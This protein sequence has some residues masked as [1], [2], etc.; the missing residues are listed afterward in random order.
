[1]VFGQDGE[2]FID[3]H[4][5]TDPY[6]RELERKLRESS[7]DAEKLLGAIG[8][9]W[10]E[11]LADGVSDELGRHGK[12]Y[13]KAVEDATQRTT[14]RIRSGFSVDRRG[15]LHDAAGRFARMFGEEVDEEFERMAAPGG[16]L[17]R[18]GQGFADAIG[19]G[20]NISGRSPLIALLIPI[21]GAIAAAIG[22]AIQAVNAL[23]GLIATLPALL[24]AVGLQVGVL[25]I[26]F[27]GL[28]ERIQ[29]AFAATNAKELEKVLF[30][31]EEPAKRFVRSLLPLRDFWRDLQM[32]VR[33]NFFG[34]LQDPITKILGAL[35][36]PALVGFSNLA[37][38]M[39][40]FF[41]G[42]GTFF[43]SP[44]F[45]DFINDVFPATIRW[46]QQF[47]G[48]FLK[49]LE[50]LIRVADAALPFLESFG[51]LISNNLSLIADVLNENVA[52]GD[53]R[54]WLDSMEDTLVSVF[55]LLGSVIQFTATFLQQLDQ[56]GGK[57]LIDELTRFFGVMTTFLAS[58]LGQKALEGLISAL[59]TS[60]QVTGGLI[61]VLLTL[62]AVAEFVREAIAE[63]FKFL[64]LMFGKAADFI[65]GVAEGIY[66]FF[67]NLG[68]PI[69]TVLTGI[70]DTIVRQFERVENLLFDAGKALV[71][72]FINGI[73]A[74]ARPL[75]E[76]GGFIVNTIKRFLPGSPADE[77][78]FSGSG[79]TLYRGQRM[80][81]DLIKGI[82]MESPELRDASMDAVSNITFGKGAIQVGFEGVV[83]TQ[84]Q[85][86]RTGS[87]VG[88]GITAILAPQRTR[89]A[90][91][92]L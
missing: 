12:D 33:N 73:K 41:N 18:I 55:Q 60:V 43:A 38:A 48:S 62:F 86:E 72:G 65:A 6:E 13:G 30:G 51:R 40:Q 75:E 82:R 49:L 89:L 24:A 15:R 22:A 53:L 50:S 17:N 31:L 61:V 21:F 68:N 3:V 39:G 76:A 87:A 57:K 81:Q 78:P 46:V 16:P 28:G 80:V 63:F 10:G 64:F 37:V 58:P 84:S 56:A 66:R 47:G 36:G 70:K 1:M 9:D 35:R 42:L 52:N 14:V 20:F 32:V 85:A 69:Q 7:K 83:P 23:I 88:N 74:M 4:A 71:R 91:R 90:V 79:Y 11:E 54:A 26:A 67:R 29:A 5:N 19:A 2:A 34:Q 45:V 44:L 59:T 92:T 77:G 8:K 27:Q 25:F